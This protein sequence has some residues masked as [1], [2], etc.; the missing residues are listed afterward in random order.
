MKNHELDDFY[1]HQGTNFYVYRYLGANLIKRTPRY[2]YSFRTWAP[3]AHSVMLVSD[4]CGWDTPMPMT[5]ITDGGVWEV[6]VKSDRSLDGE[7]YKFKII[8]KNGE[9]LKGDP[10]ATLSRG[11][12]DGASI[13]CTQS[14][15]KW[16]DIAWRRY[17][18]KTYSHVGEYYLS[19]PVNIYEI[20]LGSF[21]RKDGKYLSY[22]ELADKIAPYVKA[23]GYTH[24]ELLPI[25]EYPYDGSWGYQP[26][27]FFAPTSR[28]GT[29]DD[30]R[31]F[32]NTLHSFGIGVI[33]DWVPAHF[34]KDEWG[35][36]EFDGD[37]LYEYQGGD[38]MESASWGTR[39]FDLGR[40]EVQSFLISN[41]L[42][43]LREFHI[44]GLRT[45]AVA[46][47]IYLDYDRS[48]GAW[49]PNTNGTNENLEATAFLKKLNSAVFGEF[50]DVLMI[51]EESGSRG[52]ITKPVSLGG[53]GF[54]M[55]WN[56]GFANDLYDYLSKDPIYRAS[57]HRALNFPIMYA[58]LENYCLPISHDEVVHGKR[59]F[60]DK[61]HGSYEDKFLQARAALLL[62][63]CYPGKKLAFMGT[64]FAQFREWD[65]DS[66]LEWFMLDYPKHYEFREY[67][68]ALNRFY[69]A[70][71]SLWERD[72]DSSG[73]R[74]IL[75]DEAEKNTVAFE[76]ISTEGKTL[77]VIISFSGAAQTVTIPS[78]AFG[79]RA[80]FDSSGAL[81]GA[82][83]APSSDRDYC[84]VTLP[85]FTGVVMVKNE[86]AK[87]IKIKEGEDSVL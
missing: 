36:Y 45:D 85:P 78:D 42:Y 68:A 53:L 5:R 34:P 23:M 37:P 35:L 63:M 62:M 67:V 39:F 8:G 51:A 59:S 27:A 7:A 40:E 61:M 2:E 20:H 14:T 1:F 17:R 12:D 26:C 13:V 69:L 64:E 87:K 24:V 22:R 56:M 57:A 29:P 65:Y 9:H 47:M 80:V 55:K 77:T 31:Y 50:P 82:V 79:Y 81:S 11:G 84:N 32:V 60:I 3:N 28:F 52:G 46:A 74:W 19:S 10:Y 33:M 15:H 21:L 86:K 83:Y 16:T 49:I 76:R 70:S 30:F 58:F 72:F 18:K 48:P 75:P 73:F 41:A 6:L 44:D 25:A 4:F 66:E 43:Y 71:P 54:S 38:R